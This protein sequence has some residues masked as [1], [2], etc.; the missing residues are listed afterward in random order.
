[1]TSN[2]VLRVDAS[3][4]IAGSLTRRMTDAIVR[5]LAP[6]TVIPRDLACPIPQID[7]AWV[8]ANFTAPHE[9]S[10]DQDQVL[11]LSDRLVAEVQEADSLV[12]GVPIYNFGVPSALKAWIDQVARAG[13]TFR[14]TPD[15]PVGLLDGK[16]ATLAVASG[17]T[18]VGSNLDFAT[19]YMRH[20]LGFLGINDVTVVDAKSEEGQALLA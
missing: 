14:Y 9:R 18:V 3:A 17:G 20:V 1:M 6:N 12:I 2:T 5:R 16:A 19:G 11:T 10:D 15:G 13:V 8:G 7:E 4:R